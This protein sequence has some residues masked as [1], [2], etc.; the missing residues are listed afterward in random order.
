[1]IFQSISYIFD[2]FGHFAL[3]YLTCLEIIN[4]NEEIPPEVK[5]EEEKSKK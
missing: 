3:S 5:L 4:F 1:M 2:Y